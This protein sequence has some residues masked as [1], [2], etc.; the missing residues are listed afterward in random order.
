ME[1]S[2]LAGCEGQRGVQKIQVVGL[3]GSDEGE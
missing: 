2:E 3:G 1:K